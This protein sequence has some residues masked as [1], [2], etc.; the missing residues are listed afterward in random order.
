MR[1]YPKISVITVSYN[2]GE[3]IRDTIESVLAQNYPNFEHIIIDGGSSDDTV[4]ILKEYPHLIWTSEPD[5]GQCDGLNKGFAR[6]TGDIIAWINSDDWYAPGIFSAIAEQLRG[7]CHICLAPAQE[8][9]RDKNP[10]QLVQ[11]HLRSK[12]DLARYWIPYAWLAQPGVFFTRHA[13]ETVKFSENCY[14][15]ESLYFCMDM[16][17]WMRLFAAFPEIAHIDKIAAYYRMYESNKTGERALAG[18]RECMRVFRRYER[19]WS[20]S[21]T[22]YSFVIPLDHTD[23]LVNQ[24]LQSILNQTLPAYEIIFV[25]YS[26]NRANHKQIKNLCFD[27]AEQINHINFRYEKAEAPNFLSALKMGASKAAATIL[28]F[29]PAGTVYPP[30]FLAESSR[31]FNRDLAGAVLPLAQ[32]PDLHK[33]LF[34]EQSNGL[35]FFGLGS[36]GNLSPNLLIRKQAFMELCLQLSEDLSDLFIKQLLIGLV[37]K[38]WWVDLSTRIGCSKVALKRNLSTAELAVINPLIEAQLVVEQFEQTQQTAFSRFKAS[39]HYSPRF[40]PEL[41]TQAR[42]TLQQNPGNWAMLPNLNDVAIFQ[43]LVKQFPI[44]ALV[45]HYSSQV[46]SQ[47][48]KEETNQATQ[49]ALKDLLL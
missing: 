12:Y 2:Q 32:D 28:C 3:F 11:N 22:Q 23:P 19:S 14:L 15:D 40:T 37:F 47:A 34:N 30:E 41:I 36:T 5:R 44:S 38:G 45:W 29:T 7:D 18:Q 4:N 9:D 43:N 27:L 17:L 21:E 33:K 49:K 31:T 8:T 20:Q 35:D 13:L 1:T 16:D 39:E 10:R 42:N 48:N 6:A 24:T 25:D 46:L 26:S